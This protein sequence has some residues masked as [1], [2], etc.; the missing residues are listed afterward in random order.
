MIKCFILALNVLRCLIWPGSMWWSGEVSTM[1]RAPTWDTCSCGYSQ[2]DLGVHFDVFCQ[3]VAAPVCFWSGRG[4][5][6]IKILGGYP[7]QGS[8]IDLGLLFVLPHSSIAQYG[9][10]V[11]CT[12]AMGLRSLFIVWKI[13]GCADGCDQL[14]LKPLCNAPSLWP[15]YTVWHLLTRH[16]SSGTWCH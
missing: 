8:I 11:T 2:F 12:H 7:N 16:T 6:S 9:H 13:G 15:I 14:P 10:H 4:L 5:Y 1:M 3:D